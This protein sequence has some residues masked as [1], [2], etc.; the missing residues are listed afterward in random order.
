MQQ[1]LIQALLFLDSEQIGAK[2]RKKVPHFEQFEKTLSSSAMQTNDPGIAASLTAEGSNAANLPFFL[3]PLL[4]PVPFSSFYASPFSSFPS[5]GSLN[6]ATMAGESEQSQL[7]P[8][9]EEG[10][11]TSG[12][13]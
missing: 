3:N 8:P 10:P 9:G 6:L 5:Y 7:Q 11:S 4:N 2:R 1:N 13:P 12:I